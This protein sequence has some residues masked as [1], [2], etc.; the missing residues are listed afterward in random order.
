MP[1]LARVRPGLNGA[2]VPVEARE[3]SQRAGEVLAADWPG[4]PAGRKALTRLDAWLRAEGHA[5]IP[6][7]TADLVT[8]TLFVALRKLVIG[9]PPELPWSCPALA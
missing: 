6:G 1:D 7:A 8:A 4:Q 2:P 3:A 5:R 9:M